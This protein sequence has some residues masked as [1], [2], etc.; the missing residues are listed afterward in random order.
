MP[1]AS[2]R[3]NYLRRC[4]RTVNN[5]DA[6]RHRT[7]VASHTE[8][9]LGVSNQRSLFAKRGKVNGWCEGCPNNI[10]LPLGRRH[11]Q[12]LSLTYGKVP[13][14]WCRSH[15][16]FRSPQEGQLYG[17]LPLSN[18]YGIPSLAVSDAA[19]EG[20]DSS[21]DPAIK[22]EMAWLLAFFLLLLPL[23]SMTLL[24]ISFITS[25]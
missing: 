19:P 16:P 5:D 1:E 20:A 18:A 22:C 25:T 10:S 7:M 9:P 3:D 17:W 15:Q 24:G 2:D 11:E 12:P 23:R 21:R 4:R 14:V 6:F 8:T 13:G